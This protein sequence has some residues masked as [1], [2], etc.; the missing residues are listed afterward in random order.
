M[1]DEKRFRTTLARRLA[2]RDFDVTQASSGQGAIEAARRQE[3]DL[4]LLDLNMPGMSGEQVLDVLKQE[5]PFIEVIIL[6]GHGSVESAVHC[7]QTGSYGYLQKPCELDELMEAL[8]EAYQ[9]RVQR[10]LR[11]DRTEI[12][13]ILHK[14]AADSPLGV[15]RRLKE[16]DEAM[17]RREP[18]GAASK[19]DSGYPRMLA[20]VSIAL[21]AVTGLTVYVIHENAAFAATIITSVLLFWTMAFIYNRRMKRQ[22][23]LTQASLHETE[24]I[25]ERVVE[26]ATDLI[27]ILD[28]DMRIG[29][30]NRHAAEV[31][32]GLA[33]EAG[34]P[35]ALTGRNLTE[36][37]RP[38]DAHAI[39]AR[40][41][42]VLMTGASHSFDHKVVIDDR[43]KHF[44]TKLVPIRDDRGRIYGVLG[45]G[46]DVT[47]QRTMD[48]QIYNTEKLASVGTLAAG[49]AHEINNPLAIILGFTDLLL[50]RFEPGTPEHDDLGIIDEKANHA[51]RIVD[52]LLGFARVTEGMEDVVN[53]NRCL[54]TVV[55]I[56]R[57]TIMTK[58]IDL[59]IELPEQLPCVRGDAREFQQVVFNLIN[60][61]I[62]AMEDSGG[63]LTLSARVEG[64]QVLVGVSDTG[65][66][67]PDRIKPRIFDPFF[68]TKKVGEGTGL[69]LSLCYGMI[70]KFGGTMEYE[71]RSREDNPDSTTGTTFTLSIPVH[72]SQ[73]PIR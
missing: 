19:S 55:G 4:A 29:L 42:K 41:R 16:L 14:A 73:T 53:V 62:A 33:P 68:T 69:G 43:N 25:Y 66:G 38:D 35:D 5:H 47:E 1:D 60:N 21:L 30:I 28:P 58:K 39:Q 57:N 20:W 54:E 26:Q 59:V 17:G 49:V 65:T 70:R 18:A 67:I 12:D 46:R 63:T 31:L 37:F 6:T 52:N 36:L 56:V 61:A 51:K 50:E 71:S 9:R 24:R 34:N 64:N 72:Q 2:L 23:R 40:I 32:A 10:K 22:E 7:T 27:F 11:M 13:D 8:K 44:S 15:I 48:R 3:F 45:I